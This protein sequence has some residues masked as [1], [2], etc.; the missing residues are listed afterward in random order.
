M[1]NPNVFSRRSS[2]RTTALL[3]FFICFP[4]AL[5]SRYT[6]NYNYSQLHLQVSPGLDQ[7]GT[8]VLFRNL[9][10]LYRVTTRNEENKRIFSM[11]ASVE[12]ITGFRI[13]TSPGTQPLPQ[14]LTLRI[15][16]SWAAPNTTQP[17][18]SVQSG[19]APAASE[20]DAQPLQTTTDFTCAPQVFSRLPGLPAAI[21]WQGDG[22]LFL[23]PLLQATLC[24]GLSYLVILLLRLN[25]PTRPG[26][27][28]AEQMKPQPAWLTIAALAVKLPLC[29]LLLQLLLA[30][31]RDFWFVRSG[32]QFAVSVILGTLLFGCGWL[33]VR[34]VRAA[35]SDRRRVSLAAA[36]LL[37]LL[38]AK[39]VWV[40]AIDTSLT[41][42]YEKYRRYGIALATGQS[43][44]IG[45]K[46]WSTRYVYLQRAAFTTTPIALLCGTGILPLEL[47]NVLLQ[48]ATCLGFGWLTSRFF[49]IT[50]GCIAAPLL[51]VYPA[52]WY[53][54]TLATPQIPGF[55]SIC[56]LWIAVEKLRAFLQKLN[57]S[58]LRT[59]AAIHWALLTLI[60]AVLTTLTELQ[61]TYGLFV[62]LAV[63]A[64]AAA[65]IIMTR[66]KIRPKNSLRQFLPV[67]LGF[68]TFYFTAQIMYRSTVAVKNWITTTTGP[69]QTQSLLDSIS[70]V[71]STGNGSAESVSL[72]RFA[73]I[74]QVPQSWRNELLI[75]KT[76]HEK[77]SAGSELL[78]C[79]LR[80][81]AAIGVHEL[82]DHMTKIWGARYGLKEGFEEALRVPWWWT[83]YRVSLAMQALLLLLSLARICLPGLT[84]VSLAELFPL[85]FVLFIY[86]F[87]LFFHESGPY[88]GQI[89][90]FPLCWSAATVLAADFSHPSSQKSM[91]VNM[92]M[93]AGALAMWVILILL[94]SLLGVL[95]EKYSPPFLRAALVPD[96][97]SKADPNSAISIGIRSA[98]QLKPV[99]GQYPQGA[100]SQATFLVPNAFAKGDV[101][102]FFLSTDARS[103]NIYRTNLWW[104]KL[105]V[106]WQLAANGRILRT[107]SLGDLQPPLLTHIA[108]T[109]LPA[110]DTQQ[111]NDLRL[112]VSLETNEPI[113]MP[114][115]GFD[116]AVA[117]EYIFNPL[118]P[119]PTAS[120]IP[121]TTPSVPLKSN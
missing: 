119:P 59:P 81:N 23:V 110:S 47:V 112:T 95:L 9:Q 84:R 100:K 85:T 101:V 37:L 43:D 57:G 86:V 12:P 29:L 58:S 98:V 115:I 94:H 108:K 102:A 64:A 82:Q 71:E 15:G 5:W 87:V 50:A 66:Q 116:P 118:T 19:A 97:T 74:P 33:Y 56:L 75:R 60:I 8:Q 48:I 25:L 45:D 79:A 68:A 70:A 24:A 121:A 92:R 4:L 113:P 38:C 88:Y 103:R 114:A 107:G 83:Q 39:L 30:P 44:L 117:I 67:F 106:K 46:H 69:A 20:H 62:F 99:A 72:W 18:E 21:N 1:S 53:S 14:E 27:L 7:P 77:I 105:P 73:Y 90:A 63:P 80:K 78:M 65:G 52:F 13:I 76:M 104:D 61:K 51:A 34:A 22:W 26:T 6:G 91:A 3:A 55:L 17:I 93:A 89:L 41:G 28:S 11:L 111:T 42:D 2:G 120:A 96:S 36:A 16:T 54:P 10:G 31:V 109:D 40:L 35:A 49:N 32:L